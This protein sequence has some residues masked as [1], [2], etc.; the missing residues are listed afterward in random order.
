MPRVEPECDR[1]RQPRPANAWRQRH[2]GH[3]VETMVAV[4]KARSS[5]GQTA[6]LSLAASF[7]C[8]T[9]S[10]CMHEPMHRRLHRTL[11]NA[12]EQSRALV[13]LRHHPLVC[14]PD[15]SCSRSICSQSIYFMSAK[16]CLCITRRIPGPHSRLAPTY[17]H[18]QAR[19]TRSLITS[20]ISSAQKYHRRARTA[21]LAE[22]RSPA[23][24]PPRST[25]TNP[26]TDSTGIRLSAQS[27]RIRVHK[28]TALRP[29]ATYDWREEFEK[30]S[31]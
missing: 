30:T 2:F 15:V 11:R 19:L 20:F 12:H 22:S 31:Q 3:F 24:G 14:R 23:P 4:P 18:T 7:Q 8:P 26:P 5:S 1:S 9:A 25:A 13:R 28:S 6:K 21:F 10:T 17:S 27:E 29:H 16:L